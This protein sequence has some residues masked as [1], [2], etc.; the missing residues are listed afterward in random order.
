MGTSEVVGFSVALAFAVLVI[1][2]VLVYLL[3]TRGADYLRW[4][5]IL[6]PIISYGV[7]FGILA[8]SNYGSCGTVRPELVARAS[9]F[10]SVSSLFFRLLATIPFFRDFIIPV[11]PVEIQQEYG[12]ATAILF[13]HFWAGLY[14]GA[15]GVGFTQ[16]CN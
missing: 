14:G 1:Q 5:W 11:L 16:S 3:S 13:Y 12:Y 6:L 4:S 15:I 10:T 7:A 2:T 9:L 8:G